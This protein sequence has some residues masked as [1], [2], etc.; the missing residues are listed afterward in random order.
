MVYSSTGYK[1]ELK[2]QC[3]Y[4]YNGIYNCQLEDDERCAE[5]VKL[6]CRYYYPKPNTQ[7]QNGMRDT[8]D[9]NY[10]KQTPLYTDE[11][12]HTHACPIHSKEERT[13]E[14]EGGGGG[15]GMTCC[16]IH[17]RVDGCVASTLHD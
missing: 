1:L 11:N 13:I 15:R 3:V 9:Y 14:S 2:V 12:K 17:T 10:W 5:L 6:R 4:V 7:T 8:Q 16:P